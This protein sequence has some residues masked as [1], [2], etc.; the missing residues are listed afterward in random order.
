[1]NLDLKIFIMQNFDLPMEAL[2][3]LADRKF[4]ATADEVH[5]I[6]ADLMVVR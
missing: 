1:M 5:A 4:G 2:N 6:V 3:K